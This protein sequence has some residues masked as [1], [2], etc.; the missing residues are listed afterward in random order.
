TS[1]TERVAEAA[2]ATDAA[3]VVNV[4]GDEPMLDPEL[5]DQTV[6]PLLADPEVSLSTAS[7]PLLSVEEMLDPGVVKVVVDA[8]QDALYF[9]RSP[10]PYVRV[11]GGSARDVA[12]AAVSRR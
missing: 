7:L 1:G 5:I 6:A 3:I 8:R 2:A 4:Q 9:S 11:A 10:I 12:A